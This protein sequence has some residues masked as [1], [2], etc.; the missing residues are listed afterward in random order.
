MSFLPFLLGAEKTASVVKERQQIILA[1]ERSGR[2]TSRA[3]CLP[4]QPQRELRAVISEYFNIAP[5]DIP[6]SLERQDKLKVT[7]VRIELPEGVR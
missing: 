1:H 5:V 4:L 7:E 2:G 6:V 3:D